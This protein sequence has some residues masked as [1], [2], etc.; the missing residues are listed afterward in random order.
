MHYS[1]FL[2]L[3]LV[4]RTISQTFMTL[5]QNVDVFSTGK[6]HQNMEYIILTDLGMQKAM[7]IRPSELSVNKP[8]LSYLVLSQSIICLGDNLLK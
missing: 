4:I 5:M 2:A 3:L 8:S 7:A 1:F 6:Q